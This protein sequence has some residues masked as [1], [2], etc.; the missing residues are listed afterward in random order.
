MVYVLDT[1]VAAATPPGRGAV[2]IIRLSGPAAIAITQ[3]L[4][5]PLAASRAAIERELRLGEIRDPAMG[6]VL[7]RAMCVVFRAPRSLTGEDV[8]E[9]HCHGGPYLIRRVLALACDFGARLATPGEFT[10]RAYLNGRIDLT[11]AEAIADLIDARGEAALSQAVA[12]LDGALARRVDGLRDRLIVLRA[13]LEAEIDFADEDL[14]LPARDQLVGEIDIITADVQALLDSFIRGRL[15]RDGVRVAI[16]GKPNAGKSSIL[17]LLLGRDRAIVTAIPGTTR[18][19]IEDTINLGPYA[20]VLQDTAGI[21]D[22]RDEVEQIGIARSRRSAADADLLLALFDSS[23]PF[24]DDDAETIAL[25]AGRMG[26]GVLNKC[27]LPS[28]FPLPELRSHGLTLPVL[29][30]SATTAQGLDRLCAEMVATIEK[31]TGASSSTEIAISRERHRAALAEASAALAAT[32]ESA[33]RDMPPEL[34]AFDLMLAVDALTLLTGA[35]TNEDVLDAVFKQFC[36]G[37]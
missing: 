35:I 14:V 17:N 10:R 25:T 33:L 7:D 4:W 26:L 36:I 16:I 11:A 3:T 2:A 13:G 32:R 9:L 22:S 15:M 34:I 37:K 24:D 6:A 21:R 1:I 19:V 31:M 12:Q 29:D 20:L 23:R 5:R 30:F 8:T 27:D 18:D 28:S